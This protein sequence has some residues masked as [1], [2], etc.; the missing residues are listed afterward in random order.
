MKRLLIKM[1]KKQIEKSGYKI[2]KSSMIQ[3]M[4][5]YWMRLLL[6]FKKI[7]EN[8]INELSLKFLLKIFMV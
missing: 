2:R 5:D 1:M 6:Y 8:I 4:K 3:P 7:F